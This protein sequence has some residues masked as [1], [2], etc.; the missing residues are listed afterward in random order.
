MTFLKCILTHKNPLLVRNDF[1]PMSYFFQFRSNFLISPPCICFAPFQY[2]TEFASM[3]Q[4][5]L[6]MS[7]M[8]SH[9]RQ[10]CSL[11]SPCNAGLCSTREKQSKHF[12]GMLSAQGSCFCKTQLA[13]IRCVT[14]YYQSVYTSDVTTGLGQRA[15]VGFITHPDPSSH[16]S[17]P[18]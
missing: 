8:L 16:P 7:A 14:L 6:A 11:D 1:C 2:K 5:Q 12:E 18:T 10:G 9:I 3:R 13:H 4:L 17:S 15:F